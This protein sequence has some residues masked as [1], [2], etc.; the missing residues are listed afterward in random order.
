[1]CKIDMFS[2]HWNRL[3]E[4]PAI[5]LGKYRSVGATTLKRDE[6]WRG[7]VEYYLG[8][9]PASVA[10]KHYSAEADPPFF[11]AL[12]FLRGEIFGPEQ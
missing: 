2:T 3:A 8:H 12:R 9:A 7:F 5:P 6:V 10:D 1:M 11:K 4:K